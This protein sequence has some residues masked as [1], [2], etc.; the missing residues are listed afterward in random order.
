MKPEKGYYSVIQYCPDLGRFEAANMGVLLFCP[1]SGFLKSL[2]SGNNSRI[3]KFFGS[4][5]PIGEG[6]SFHSDARRHP[7]VYFH[8]SQFHPNHSTAS[9]EGLRS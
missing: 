6:T 1:E 9:N 4:E 8:S 5:G 3:I 2:M 7:D